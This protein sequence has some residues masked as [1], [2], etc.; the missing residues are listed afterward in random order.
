M[1]VGYKEIVLM[2][3]YIGGYGE[4]IKDYNLVGLFCDMEVEVGGLKCFCIFFIEVS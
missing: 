2:G 4:D 1:D 3:I